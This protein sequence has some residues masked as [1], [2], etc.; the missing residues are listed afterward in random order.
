MLVLYLTNNDNQVDQYSYRSLYIIYNT[1]KFEGFVA[2][3]G[4]HVPQRLRIT[5]AP[6]SGSS[7]KLSLI[8]LKEGDMELQAKHILLGGE[9]PPES[10]PRRGKV[11]LLCRF[12]RGFHSCYQD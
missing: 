7:E 4:A 11:T 5:L 2:T 9:L 8:M 1:H 12:T 10:V 6:L 3:P